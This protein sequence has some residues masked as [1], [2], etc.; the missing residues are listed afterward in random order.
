MSFAQISSQETLLRELRS[1][2]SKIPAPAFLYNARVTESAD[3]FMILSVTDASRIP[4]QWSQQQLCFSYSD[5]A[6]RIATTPEGVPPLLGMDSYIPHS[7]FVQMTLCS[8][9]RC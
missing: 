4:A 8:P 7:S 3:S 1:P 9:A 5:R 2:S 6:A